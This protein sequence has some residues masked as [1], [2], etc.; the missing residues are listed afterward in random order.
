MPNEI[1]R[2]DESQ[3]RDERHRKWG[4][5]F[6]A[7]LDGYVAIRNLPVISAYS[8]DDEVPRNKTI[9]CDYV[10]FV[11]DVENALNAAIGSDPTLYEA[12]LILVDGGTV[13]S[14]IL[15]RLAIKAGRVFNERGLHPSKQYFKVIKKGRRDW[16]P[17]LLAHAPA[18]VAA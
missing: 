15:S 18:Q 16:R 9:T 13:T 2:F 12:W 6:N 11:T 10:H 8:Y 4:R 14:G 5:I 3:K 17:Y 1:D 7:V